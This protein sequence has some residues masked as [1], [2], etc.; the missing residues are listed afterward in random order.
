METD[1]QIVARVL[2][3]D[4]EAYALLVQRHER[5]A[6][7]VAARVLKDL[8]SADDA[9]QEALVAAFQNL[10]RLRNPDAFGGWL[11]RIARR[12][13][14]RLVS[15]Q[16]RRQHLV[17]SAVMPESDNSRLDPAS[18]GLLEAMDSLRPPLRHVLM[19]HYFQSHSVRDIAAMSAL[20]V[21]TVTKQ[22]TRAREQLRRRLEGP[23]HV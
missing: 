2:A 1:A 18:A 6:W 21:G 8:H 23:N 3:G 20:A 11:M 10:G 17:K 22:L 14:L 15:A 12:E 16:R 7:G 9:A 5:A 13:A 19:L 4:R